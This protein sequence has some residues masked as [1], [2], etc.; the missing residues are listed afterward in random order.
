MSRQLVITHEFM[1]LMLGVRRP[2]ITDAVHIL[3]G[4][5]A[6][7]AGR[8]QVTITDRKALEKAA[9]WTYGIAEAEYERLFGRPRNNE[10]QTVL[11]SLETSGE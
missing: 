2:G 11:D 4:N 9:G 7:H 5:G 3:E 1:A 10:V 6:I 8:G